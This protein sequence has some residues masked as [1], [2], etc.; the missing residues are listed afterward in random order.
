MS[1]HPREALPELMDG[2]LAERRRAEVEAHLKDCGPCRAELA[3]L[4]E[5]SALV[6]ALPERPLPAGFLHR[7]QRR[8]R[9]EQAP[10]ASRKPRY[11][12]PLPARLAAF[13]L[14]SLIVSLVIYDKV[15]LM[16]PLHGGTPAF[17]A[18]AEDR[19][20]P[21]TALSAA[22]LEQARAA[23][24][25]RRLK[26][27]RGEP[28][29]GRAAADA[30][31][32]GALAAAPVPPG[33][34]A[35]TNEEL[36]LHLESEKRK[37]GIRGYA[38][39]P[40]PEVA[41]YLK[42]RAGLDAQ[43]LKANPPP[44]PVAGEAPALLSDGAAGSA[45]LPSEKGAPITEAAAAASAN[46]AAPQ[47]AEGLVLKSAEECSKAWAERSMHAAPPSVDFKTGMVALVVAPD[48]KSAV[49]VL[50]VETRAAGVFV[51]YRLFPRLG[52][53]A[54]PGR[55]GAAPVRSYQ[56]R[57]LPRTDKPVVFLRVD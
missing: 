1:G 57:V 31:G 37:A 11:L 8:R 21:S 50:G 5:V 14:S 29:E 51:K 41:A 13:A 19:R 33:I 22:D 34:S 48:L 40:P 27:A 20:L 3:K 17:S 12:L 30:A 23:G 47:G 55:A 15:R 25:G 45:P 52:E 44:A 10:A 7:L 39:K 32:A 24:L 49:E 28:L 56:F 36:L 35:R 4:R 46:A 54:V 2:E 26:Q 53:V 18:P 9:E 43:A 16:V 6:R 38:A 42:L